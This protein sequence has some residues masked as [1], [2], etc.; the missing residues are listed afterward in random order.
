MYLRVMG[1]R[2][3]VK[4]TTVDEILQRAC[5]MR[6]AKRTHSPSGID[7]QGVI[8]EGALLSTREG[9]TGKRGGEWRGS[10]SCSCKQM[11]IRKIK[12]NVH[13]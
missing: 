4:T 1:G 10:S 11:S 2:G 8:E 3:V 9:A 7:I 6:R 12:L 5:T 13:Q